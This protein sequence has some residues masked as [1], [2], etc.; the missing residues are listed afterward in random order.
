[1]DMQKHCRRLTVESGSAEKRFRR[2]SQMVPNSVVSSPWMMIFSSFIIAWERG[3]SHHPRREKTKKGKS[4]KK[5]LS[6]ESPCRPLRE[7]IMNFFYLAIFPIVIGFLFF[8]LPT[9][10][11]RTPDIRSRPPRTAWTVP[12]RNRN[13]GR[14]PHPSCRSGRPPWRSGTLPRPRPP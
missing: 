4:R 8:S 13:S 10:P 1:M 11:K 14:S 3:H 12:D 2:L 5:E 9:L 6:E 7:T